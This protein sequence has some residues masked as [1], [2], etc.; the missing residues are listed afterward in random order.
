[1]AECDAWV[2]NKMM[3]SGSMGA[4]MGA[5]ARDRVGPRDYHAITP[6]LP[7]SSRERSGG[8]G[9]FTEIPPVSARLRV[10]AGGLD[11]SSSYDGDSANGS[12]SV[13]DM[14]ASE[15]GRANSN[16]GA[17]QRLMALLEKQGHPMT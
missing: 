4:V 11:D 7:S 12:V 3:L 10:G 13:K 15:G 6:F 17:L 14:V 1:V 8:G 2:N 16:S 5:G 9:E